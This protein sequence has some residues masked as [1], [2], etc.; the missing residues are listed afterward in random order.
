MGKIMYFF[1]G[2]VFIVNAFNKISD[3]MVVNLCQR[4]MN[5][6]NGPV[7]RIILLYRI[8]V[9]FLDKNPHW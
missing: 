1:N 9:Y 7:H 5:L 4:I 6:S 3:Y 8:K 2:V